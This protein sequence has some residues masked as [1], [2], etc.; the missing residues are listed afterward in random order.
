[1]CLAVL[2]QTHIAKRNMAA[3]TLPG[4][5]VQITVVDRQSM[6]KDGSHKDTD[7]LLPKLDPARLHGGLDSPARRLLGVPTHILAGAAYCTGISHHDLVSQE[8]HNSGK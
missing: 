1:L 8:R 6:A 5:N 2:F 7:A 4:A 3:D